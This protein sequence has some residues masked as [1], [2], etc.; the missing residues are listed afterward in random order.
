MSFQVADRVKE[1]SASVGTGT[2]TLDG[3]QISFQSFA[4]GIGDGN[5]TYYCISHRNANEF[6]VGVGTVVL[7]APNS[8]TRDT[9]LASS[10]GGSLVN[11]S[12]G[13][14]DV[15]CTYPAGKFVHL[16]ENEGVGAL[17]AADLNLLSQVFS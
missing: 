1:T 4:S 17:S 6:E 11:F 14:K 9:I 7:G 5:K 8:L 16:G 2:I 12:S 10:N 3:P 13:T 15:F